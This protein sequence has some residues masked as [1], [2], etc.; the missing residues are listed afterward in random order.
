MCLHVLLCNFV[1]ISILHL[2]NE[3]YL[4]CIY[5]LKKSQGFYKEKKISVSHLTFNLQVS[6]LS[7]SRN[8]VFPL[9]KAN[10][11]KE[12]EST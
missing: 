7:I 10:V 1:L 5:A 3:S 11:Y 9:E 8:L 12:K 2:L 6:S 4:L